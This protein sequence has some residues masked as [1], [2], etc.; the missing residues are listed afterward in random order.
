MGARC[1]TAAALAAATAWMHVRPRRFAIQRAFLRACGGS[2]SFTRY[3]RS[4][5][6]VESKIRLQ[7]GVQLLDWR[8]IETQFREESQACASGKAVESS[9]RH[10]AN[11]RASRVM[12]TLGAIPL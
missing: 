2:E 4:C 8:C 1:I 11:A 7:A 6:R 12:R 5:F 3:I 9:E 10:V